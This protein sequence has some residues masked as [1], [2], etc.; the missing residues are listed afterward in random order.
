MI[1]HLLRVPQFEIM[2]LYNLVAR[3]GARVA[4][5]LGHILLL[6]SCFDETFVPQR[7]EQDCKF[8][9]VWKD[10]FD[11]ATKEPRS[12]LF[13]LAKDAEVQR[14][15]IST[16]GN[17]G[18]LSLFPTLMLKTAKFAKIVFGISLFVEPNLGKQYV[19]LPPTELS[20]VFKDT[21][22]A[23]PIIFVLSTGADPQGA[24][25]RF[26][27]DTDYEQRLHNLSLGQG[28][29]VKV[30]RLVSDAKRSV[31]WVCLQNCHLAK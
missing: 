11:E 18:N 14:L 7:R 6:E 5:E 4:Q 16:F 1:L 19:S 24:L 15:Q 20:Q 29:G 12:L 10:F 21:D 3:R 2:L 9:V 26:A 25:L 30:E 23:T 8:C 27:K 17:L 22:K 28:Q 13:N 31:N